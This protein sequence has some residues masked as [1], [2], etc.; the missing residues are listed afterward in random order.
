MFPLPNP[1]PTNEATQEAKCAA[2]I[3]S[4]FTKHLKPGHL[5]ASKGRVGSL[6]EQQFR[7][8]KLG[9]LPLIFQKCLAG[10]E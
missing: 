6:L 5:P 7:K 4:T 2:K 10:W 3:R 9:I 8:K 1:L